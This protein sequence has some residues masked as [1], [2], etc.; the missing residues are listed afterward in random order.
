MKKLMTLLLSLPFLSQLQAQ[1]PLL[2]E[3][4]DYQSG[5]N[6]QNNGWYSHSAGTTNPIKVSDVGLSWS[7]TPYLGS[8]VGNAALV[9]NTG[10]DENKPL[11]SWV[12]SGNVYV[13][14]L[15]NVNKAVTTS[16]QGYFFHIGEYA[17]NSSPVYTAFNSAFRARTYVV[18]G[19]S[20]AQYKLGL[21][22]NSSTAPSTAGVNITGDLDTGKTYLAIVKY[23]FISGTSNDSVSLYLFSDGDDLS[24]EP[25]TPTLGPMA[26][27]QTDLSFVQAVVLRQFNSGQGI[28]VDGIIARTDWNW[29]AAKTPVAPD[30]VGPSNNTSLHVNGPAATPVVINWTAAQNFANARY[31]WQADARASGS[32]APAALALTSDNSGSDT[33][34]SLNFGALDQVLSSLGLSVGDTLEA[35]WRVRAISG[36]DTLYSDTFNIDLIRGYMVAPLSNF[37]LLTPADETKL[38][39]GP[40][41]SQ[42][43]VISWRSS[44]AGT[45]PVS[46]QWL[47]IGPGGNFSAPAVTLASDN[48]GKDTTLTVTL[49]AL[50]NLLASLGVNQGDS[51][52]LQWTVSATADTQ[53]ILA[54]QSWYITL[55]RADRDLGSISNVSPAN[56]FSLHVSGPAETPVTIHWT[57]AT[58]LSNVVYE[59]QADLRSMGS[60]TPPAL[61]LASDNSGADTMLSLNFG[62]IDM[63]LASLG[64]NVDDTL[65]AVW[66]V[67]AIST[68]DADTLY[69]ESFNIDLIRGYIMA[70]LS[71]FNLLSPANGITVV[72]KAND[73]TEIDIVWESSTAGTMP[74]SYQWVLDTLG[75]DFS[76]PLGMLPSNNFGEDTVLTVTLAEADE[77]LADLGIAPGDSITLQWAVVASA[78]TQSRLSS[79]FFTVTLKRFKEDPASVNNRPLRT[80]NA[81]PNPNA[82]LVQL[83]FNEQVSGL[84]NIQ[85]SDAMGRVVMRTSEMAASDMSISLDGLN[86]GIYWIQ[87]QSENAGYLQRIV[88]QK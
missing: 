18:P 43:A 57:S 82:G 68:T 76:M 35:V 27:D 3:H 58:E 21:T 16:T 6:L 1:N 53:T 56:N 46:Y 37:D 30:L 84:L 2:V 14:F 51:I 70:P 20:N 50:D 8:G 66:R 41:Q 65:K 47:A 22:F 28:I 64:L 49:G 44:S 10:S 34:L 62:A 7:Q 83:Q 54:N 77:L 52:K 60:Y 13:A 32:F 75:G 45:L 69:S 88:L 26:G 15:F 86:N 31:E 80:L 42:Q 78:D 24:V 29:L 36:T 74:V 39:V 11:S 17:N 81:Y 71:P 19:S 79:N 25:S 59:W 4:F 40:G 48:S 12:S 61:A 33:V 73:L 72:T 63:V 85:I 38:D 87:V 5:T 55:K 9:N 23:H 67:R